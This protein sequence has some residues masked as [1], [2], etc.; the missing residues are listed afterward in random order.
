MTLPTTED[1]SIKTKHTSNVTKQNTQD[2][3]QRTNLL[4]QKVSN[5]PNIMQIMQIL[6]SFNR[7]HHILSSCLPHTQLFHCGRVQS[8]SRWWTADIIRSTASVV[9]VVV[10]DSG[11]QT[12]ITKCIQVDVECILFVFRLLEE[13][14]SFFKVVFTSVVD[15]TSSATIGSLLTCL[16]TLSFGNS[17]GMIG[18]GFITVLE[19]LFRL[20][21]GT[22]G[23]FSL[24]SFE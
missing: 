18:G 23:C 10:G 5:L 9:F 12:M 16:L 14:C 13:L 8:V 4:Q 2:S 21:F 24:G 6:C 15:A 19:L 17:L 1:Y 11:G 20:L 7:P 3:K 22:L